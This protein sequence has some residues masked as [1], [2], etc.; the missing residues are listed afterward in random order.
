MERRP[1]DTAARGALD[2]TLPK[3]F[4]IDVAERSVLLT[5]K[6]VIL[7]RASTALLHR[8]VRCQRS[9]GVPGGW[10]CGLRSGGHGFS[11]LADM[12]SPDDRLGQGDH[13][14]A[15]EGFSEPVTV[16]FGCHEVGVV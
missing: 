7:E 8:G 16:T 10:T 6:S 1:P 12:R 2:R 14:L 15:G 11:G 9:S 13:P 5:E 3:E 4:A